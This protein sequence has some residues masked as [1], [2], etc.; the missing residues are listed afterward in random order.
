[1]IFLEK[2]GACISTGA[3]EIMESGVG[4]FNSIAFEFY[5]LSGNQQSRAFGPVRNKQVNIGAI[6]EFIAR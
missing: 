4:D 6:E 5:R 3:D 2:I 1:M